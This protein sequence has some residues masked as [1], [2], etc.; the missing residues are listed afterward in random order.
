MSRI[1]GLGIPKWPMPFWLKSKALLG[2]IQR[3]RPAS[4]STVHQYMQEGEH[5]E[6]EPLPLLYQ[7]PLPRLLSWSRWWYIVSR[8]LLIAYQKKLWG[9]LGNYLKRPEI[10][11]AVNPHL[12]RLR[13][14]WGRGRGRVATTVE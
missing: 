13:L 14:A 7:V 8:I 10:A 9:G 2:L 1:C 5:E 4:I 3:E 12:A 11:G 6:E